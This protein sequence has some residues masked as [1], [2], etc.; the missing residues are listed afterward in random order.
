MAKISILTHDKALALV[1]KIAKGGSTFQ[2]DVQ[3]ISITAIGY[4]NVHGDV[5]IATRAYEALNL[6]KG[7]KA[8]SFVSYLEMYGCLLLAKDGFVHVK[9]NDVERDPIKLIELLSKVSWYTPIKTESTPSV[10]L[11][12]AIR[13][14]VAKAQAASAKGFTPKGIQVLDTLAVLANEIEEGLYD[15]AEGALVLEGVLLDNL[16]AHMQGAP[17]PH[18]LL[19]A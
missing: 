5:T 7:V 16:E 10:D 12:D 9:R 14:L 13:K 2:S 3:A 18:D 8:K 1:S 4:A 11:V 15:S 6:L 19:A 17:V